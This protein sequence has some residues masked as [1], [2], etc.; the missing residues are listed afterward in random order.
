MKFNPFPWLLILASLALSIWIRNQLI[1]QKEL[2]FFCAGGGHT[3]E[4]KVRW[5]IE[6]SFKH[7]GLGYFALFL[8]TLS[9]IT[10]SGFVGLLACMVGMAGLILYCWDYAAVGFLLGALTLTRAQFDDYRDQCRTSEEQK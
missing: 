6:K 4:C 8:G 3:I 5:M 9:T 7:L 2:A 1:E 10:R